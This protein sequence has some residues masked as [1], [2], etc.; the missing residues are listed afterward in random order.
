MNSYEYTN[1][2][3]NEVS[4]FQDKDIKIENLNKIIEQCKETLKYSLIII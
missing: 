3:I 2:K 4:H 1:E